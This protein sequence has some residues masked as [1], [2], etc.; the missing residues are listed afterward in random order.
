MSQE[1]V[2]FGAQIAGKISK[3]F[4]VFRT[5]PSAK[6]PR[7]ISKIQHTFF[8]LELCSELEVDI[9]KLAAREPL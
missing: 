6:T 3:M 8:N 9:V 2:V 1:S 5:K 4:V 7:D